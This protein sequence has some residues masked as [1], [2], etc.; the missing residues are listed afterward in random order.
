MSQHLPALI[1]I[2]PFLAALIA[3]MAIWLNEKFCFPI[4][5]AAL[6]VTSFSA[7]GLLF[8]VF[9]RGVVY[10]RLAGWEPPMGISY[11]IDYL[12]SLVILVI[13]GVA[14]FNLLATKRGVESELPDKIGPF[15]SLYLLFITGLIG[16]V[17]TGD[18]FN[19]YVLLEIASLSGYALI[20][21]G[22]DRA[23]LSGLN[24][25][26]MGTI[27]ASFYLLGV[28]YL[29]LVTGSLNM[30]DIASIIPQLG[31]SSVVFI[32]LLFCLVGIFLKM[33]FFPLHGWLPNA[34]SYSPFVSSSLIAPLTT[35][36]MIYVMIRMVFSIFTPAY[37]FET[38]QLAPVIVWLAVIAIIV[39]S[40]FALAQ[41]SLR[42]ML[43][44]IIVV[45]VGYMV[46]GFWLGN[47]YGITGSILHIVNDAVMTLCLFLTAGVFAY[48]LNGDSYERFKGLFRKMPFSTAAFVIGG[49]SI[50]G[51]P[52]T[53]GFFSKWYLILGGI[54]A[55]QYA[56]VFALLFSSLINAILFFRLFEICYYEPVADSDEKHHG[57]VPVS[58]SEAPIDMVIPLVLVAGLLIVLGVYAGDLVTH[59]IQHAIPAE[60]V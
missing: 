13:T 59:I 29:Y 46:G 37:A 11:R 28:G 49:F 45:E 12:N 47:R 54:A 44:Y 22:Q 10:Y 21:L 50:I 55:E 31:Q 15:Y 48:K 20:G 52:P 41:T 32:A 2:V 7:L 53:C 16:I 51:I 8:Q 40:F 25:L 39:G 42:R 18:A 33:A 3:S 4:A 38:L 34:Y 1:I 58:F 19:L 36:V 26:F 60:I 23:P 30:A 24:Y 17:A 27:G 9:Q 57:P 5:L 56:F 43:S 6:G 35:K 14:F